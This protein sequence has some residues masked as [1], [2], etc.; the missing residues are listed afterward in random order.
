M[1]NMP[2]KLRKEMSEDPFYSKCLRCK[3][4]ECG[5]RIT[6]EHCWTYK[7]RQIQE[8]WA[9][10]PLCWWHHLGA[11]LNKNMNRWFSINRMTEA[12]E[13][14]YNRKNWKTDRKYLNS[15]FKNYLK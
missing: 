5:G 3:E 15:L 6:W 2:P 9:I 12:D 4:G 11:G 10:I 7:K 14:K 8:K 1:N 13:K